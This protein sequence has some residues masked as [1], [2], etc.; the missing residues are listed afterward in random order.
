MTHPN[1]RTPPFIERAFL[2]NITNTI[3]KA[4]TLKCR[5]Y[6]KKALIDPRFS[7]DVFYRRLRDYTEVDVARV[8]F[9]LESGISL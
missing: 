1:F 3:K 2:E 6:S 8:L 9:T 5:T 4:L 7:N